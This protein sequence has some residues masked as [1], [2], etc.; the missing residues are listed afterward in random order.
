MTTERKPDDQRLVGVVHHI[1]SKTLIGDGDGG[2]DAIHFID[3]DYLVD[4]IYRVAGDEEFVLR[5]VNAKREQ[6]L[7]QKR[8]LAV[9]MTGWSVGWAGEAVCQ[10]F[11]APGQ[12]EFYPLSWP[13]PKVNWFGD[14]EDDPDGSSAVEAYQEIWS[15]D[16]MLERRRLWGTDDPPPG[17]VPPPPYV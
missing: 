14:P 15:L 16:D 5:R 2:G 1:I 13:Q 12:A 4:S 7:R 9:V 6:M 3:T 10:Y 8:L 11:P 17:S